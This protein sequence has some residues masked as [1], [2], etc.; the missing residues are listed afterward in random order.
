MNTKEKASTVHYQAVKII[1]GDPLPRNQKRTFSVEK[2][3]GKGGNGGSIH[4]LL[5]GKQKMFAII[6]R[7]GEKGMRGEKEHEIVLFGYG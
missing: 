5:I 6:P 3:G 2:E 1:P 4:H 7:T